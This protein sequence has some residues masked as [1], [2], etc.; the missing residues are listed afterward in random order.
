MGAALRLTQWV[1][2]RLKHRQRSHYS[3]QR[4]GRSIL[5]QAPLSGLALIEVNA[6]AVNGQK[7]EK[8]DAAFDFLI[9]PARE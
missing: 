5:Y 4:F 6:T 8:M 3:A 2:W 7:E 1:R 9:T